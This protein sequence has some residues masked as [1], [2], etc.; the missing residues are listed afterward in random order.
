MDAPMPRALAVAACLLAVLALPAAASAAAPPGTSAARPG[1]QTLKYRFGP[2][3][4][5]PGQNDNV[6]VP[7]DRMPQVNGWIVG[8]RPNLVRPDGTVPRVDQIH[9]HH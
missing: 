7:N 3:P 2:I 1:V 6:F 4:V 8:F 9:L 5:T